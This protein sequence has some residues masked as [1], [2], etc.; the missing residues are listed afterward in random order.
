M[1]NRCWNNHRNC[2]D[3]IPVE[4]NLT[5]RLPVGDSSP[6]NE[7]LSQMWVGY[8]RSPQERNIL[9]TLSAEYTV[10]SADQE[11]HRS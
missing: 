5:A 3:C 7:Y 9:Q 1:D 10:G 6:N 11:V 8:C 4:R 2:L